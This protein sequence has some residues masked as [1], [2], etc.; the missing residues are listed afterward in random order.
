MRVASHERR[1][2]SAAPLT[3]EV[4]ELCDGHPSPEELIRKGQM[5]ALLDLVLNQMSEELRTIFVLCELEELEV[6]EAAAI[7]NIPLGTAS[8]RL[9]RAREEFSVVARRVRAALIAR[10]GLP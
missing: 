1:R 3:A 6:R 9:R 8:S 10:G 7:E 5:R 4:D 2:R